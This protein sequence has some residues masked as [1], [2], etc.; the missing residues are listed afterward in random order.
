MSRYETAMTD[1]C[2]RIQRVYVTVLNN[3]ERVTEVFRDVRTGRPFLLSEDSGPE[4]S[5]IKTTTLNFQPLSVLK[6]IVIKSQFGIPMQLT[7]GT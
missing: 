1:S 6:A 3:Q 2:F 5:L 4:G 7:I